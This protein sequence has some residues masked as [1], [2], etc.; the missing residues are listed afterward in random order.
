EHVDR[1]VGVQPVEAAGPALW[2][3]VVRIRLGTVIGEDDGS[4]GLR[5]TDHRVVEPR[6]RLD[7]RPDL[8]ARL[9]DLHAE[10]ALPANLVAV[11]SLDR[12]HQNADPPST[13]SHAPLM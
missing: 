9:D 12:M 7:D 1:I 8:E 11:H 3:P 13:L 5:P 4:V 10:D 6:R 2:V